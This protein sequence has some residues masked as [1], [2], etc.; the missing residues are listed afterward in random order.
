MALNFKIFAKLNS[1]YGRK[2]T[3]LDSHLP[4]NK[5]TRKSPQGPTSGTKNI[6]HCRGGVL[7]LCLRITIFSLLF[8][9]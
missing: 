9:R 3:A 4:V 5:V 6:Y 8:H 2:Q 1:E 7:A